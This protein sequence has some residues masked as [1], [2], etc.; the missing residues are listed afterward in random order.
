MEQI[1][2]LKEFRLKLGLTQTDFAKLLKISRVNYH[3]FESGR[4][5]PNAKQILKFCKILKCTPNDLF[6]IKG[7]HSVWMDDLDNK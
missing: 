1:V 5:Q 7:I 3:H 2:K 6:G 4:S